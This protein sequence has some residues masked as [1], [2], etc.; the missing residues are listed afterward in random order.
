MNDVSKELIKTV[1][2]WFDIRAGED[3]PIDFDE[4]CKLILD[5]GWIETRKN[6]P[7]HTV[8]VLIVFNKVVIPAAYISS[9]TLNEMWLLDD[10][11]TVDTTSILYWRSL[12]ELPKSKS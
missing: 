5:N 9:E 8:R 12:P 1:E 3:V 4:L 6:L 10:G 7:E 2:D 11:C